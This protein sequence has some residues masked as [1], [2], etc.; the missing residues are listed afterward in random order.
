MLFIAL[1]WVR[2]GEKQAKI[3]FD[4]S[5]GHT[6]TWVN[7]FVDVIA[8]KFHATE[9]KIHSQRREKKTRKTPK[10]SRQEREKRNTHETHSESESVETAAAAAAAI[11]TAGRQAASNNRELQRQ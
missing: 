3:Q 2:I 11:A 9:K 1:K 6:K 7:S 5:A 4:I 10:I 8:K